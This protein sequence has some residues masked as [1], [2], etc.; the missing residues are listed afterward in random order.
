MNTRRFLLR[1]FAPL[2]GATPLY[3]C[4]GEAT[5]THADPDPVAAHAS[6]LP[7]ATRGRSSDSVR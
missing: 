6:G 5:D 1:T 3:G 2:L 7:L 4:A